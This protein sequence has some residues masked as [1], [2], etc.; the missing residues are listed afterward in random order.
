VVAL[1]ADKDFSLRVVEHLRG[2][3]YDSLTTPEADL[4]NANTPDNLIVAAATREGR[5]VLTYNRRD[6]GR[7]HLSGVAHAGIIV[8]TR[9]RDPSREAGRIHAAIIANEPLAGKLIRV[10]R[11]GP[12]ETSE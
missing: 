11:P 2:M 12:A 6:F 10:T 5:A 7:I 1:F 9:D 4:A 3:G 8:C